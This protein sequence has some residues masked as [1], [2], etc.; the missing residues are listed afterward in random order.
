MTEYKID[1]T[2]ADGICLAVLKDHRD[3][4]QGELDAHKEG[5]YLHPVDVVKNKKLVK[6]M[7]YLI[8]NYFDA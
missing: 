2:V 8:E 7:T 4:L 5:A 6:K 3:H 1:C